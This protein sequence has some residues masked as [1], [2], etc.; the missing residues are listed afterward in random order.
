MLQTQSVYPRTLELLKKLMAFEPLNQFNLVGG[1]ALALQVGHR[2][3]V[4]LDLFTNQLF[5]ANE[6]KWA[7]EKE[8]GKENIVWQL[9]KDH[10][11]L[12]L[13]NDIKVDIIHY[14]YPLIDDLIIENGI[15][16]L[17]SKDI[18]AMKLSAIS[19]RGSK[20]DF[21]D[22]YELLQ[23]RHTMGEMF[24][25]FKEKFSN[26]ELSFIVRSL[27]YFEDADIQEDPIMIKKVTW[28]EVQQE[29]TKRTKQFI[30]QTI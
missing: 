19:K 30:E 22:I 27:F 11:L 23:Q 8:F 13:I 29:I 9:E 26:S 28:Q 7:L 1:T 21:F 6:L 17:S 14:P 25:F 12:L 5:D 4:D 20:K 18:A 10:T 24:S 15:R 3:S 16:L 2:I